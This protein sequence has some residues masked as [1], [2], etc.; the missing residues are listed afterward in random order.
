MSSQQQQQQQGTKVVLVAISSIGWSWIQELLI[1]MNH[2]SEYS[3]PVN[4]WLSGLILVHPSSTTFSS[5]SSQ[6]QLG[7]NNLELLIPSTIPCFVI[8]STTTTI[9]TDHLKDKVT[10]NTT[11]KSF[12]S[13]LFINRPN[14][15]VLI[16]DDEHNDD[17]D[18]QSLNSREKNTN[19]QHATNPMKKYIEHYHWL[20]WLSRTV[21]R[22]T[23][24]L[25]AISSP[26][27]S[28]EQKQ[29]LFSRL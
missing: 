17:N 10:T 19:A 15:L 1:W 27:P 2:S 9:T 4:D 3:P 16:I 14:S 6:P 28:Q 21:A 26:V 12:W 18:T 11:D 29:K 24:A 25:E 22:Y 5:S 7:S 8:L 23:E 20:V 13:S